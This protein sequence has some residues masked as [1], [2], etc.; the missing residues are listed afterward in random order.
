M[1]NVKKKFD[2]QKVTKKQVENTLYQISA[3]CGDNLAKQFN[4]LSDERKR[5][6]TFLLNARLKRASRQS[7]SLDTDIV[8]EVIDNARQDFYI[9]GDEIYNGEKR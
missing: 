4:R 1:T 7:N 6:V 9:V 3:H 8:R 5:K 2:W